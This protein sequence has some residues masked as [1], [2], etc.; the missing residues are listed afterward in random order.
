MASRILDASLILL[1]LMIPFSIAGMNAAI[2][3][4]LAGWLG[5]NL[6]RFPGDGSLKRAV[7]DPIVVASLLLALSAVPSLLMSENIGRAF[8][9]WKSYWLI[10][11]YALAAYN[12]RRAGL[13]RTVYW[14]FFGSV[15]LTCA[16]ALVQ[17]FGGMDFLFIHLEHERRPGSTL[18]P[19]TLAGILYLAILLN[20]SVFAGRRRWSRPTLLIAAGILVQLIV[21]LFTL[22]RGAYIAL[23]GGLAVSL[24]LLRNKKAILGS[25]VILGVTVLF[26]TLKP[27]DLDRPLTVTS[28]VK[29]PPDRNVS[30]RLV[31]WDISLEL[32]KKHPLFGVGM[33]DFSIEADRII[34]ERKI[35][36]NV[37]SHNIYLQILATRGLFG[38]FFFALFWWIVFRE[39]LRLRNRRPAGTF[40]RQLA[41]GAIAATAALL[42]G[43]LTENN[44]DDCEVYIAFLFILGLARSA[45]STEPAA[46]DPAAQD[47]PGSQP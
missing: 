36:T 41:T 27:A 31:L 17:H 25:A 8:N 33:G 15:M 26:L 13:R 46:A 20:F 18:Y 47:L 30:T 5:L 14:V 1:A 6:A 23:W 2:F 16:V 45:V 28:L 11:V 34:R 43:A 3:L 37:D 44:I 7:R 19:M 9:D 21:L 35:K 32:F 10:V 40:E 24:L 29:A 4:G 22:T 42:C 38:L 39:L 12:L